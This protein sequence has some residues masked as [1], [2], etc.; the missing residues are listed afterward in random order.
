MTT[1]EMAI[2]FAEHGKDIGSLKRRTDALEKKTDVIQEL[3][4]SVNELAV[5]MRA[6]L[7]EQE[8]QGKKIESLESVPGKRWDTLTT[9]IIT[10]LASGIITFILTKIFGG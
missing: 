4:V 1:E 5:N 6:M 2:K 9:V 3:A 7:L 10:A 8:K